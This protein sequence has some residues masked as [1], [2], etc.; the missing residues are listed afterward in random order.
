M[1]LFG[2]I[3]SS[4]FIRISIIG[5]AIIALTYGLARFAFGLFLP[6]IREDLNINASVAG[7]IGSLP[8]ISFIIGVIIAPIICKKLNSAIA[9]GLVGS[10]AALG[11]FSI[12]EAKDLL[13]LGLGVTTC[14]L[15]TGLSSPIMASI[16]KHNIHHRLCGR[17][18]AIHNASTSVGIALAVPAIIMW[19]NDWRLA[20]LFFG[21]LATVCTIG[22]L[23]FLAGMTSFYNNTNTENKSI[24]NIKS[25]QWHEEF[26]LTFLAFC[27]GVVSSI[28]WVF[29]PDL[30]SQSSELSAKQMGWIWLAVAAGGLGGGFASELIDKFGAA[31]THASALILMS[32]SLIFTALFS[33]LIIVVLVSAISFGVSYMTIT[34]FHLVKGVQIVYQKPSFGPVLPL[35]GTTIGQAIGSGVSG[36]LIENF[37]Y[38]WSF[39]GFAVL[40]LIVALASKD[41]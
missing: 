38:Q 4:K 16:V 28:Y 19:S 5:S 37:G 10:L 21:L 13:L 2:Q 26:K 35:L 11:L 22:A 40:G 6:F 41:L 33:E 39:I 34:G 12:S 30:V 36:V 8:F 25:W 15:S 1:A 29:T 7:V 23:I 27:M 20:Y 32:L 9:A 14:G 17:V 31:K 3:K 24:W 18:N